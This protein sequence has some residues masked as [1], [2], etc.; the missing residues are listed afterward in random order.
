[1]DV[2]GAFVKIGGF[3]GSHA[4]IPREHMHLR[5]S[6][7]PENRQKSG[8][9]CA[10]PFY[11]APSLHIVEKK[12]SKESRT[13]SGTYPTKKGNPPSPGR[14]IPQHRERKINPTRK[15]SG[16]ISRENPPGYPRRQL[17]SGPLKLWKN[18]HFGPDIHDPKA[19]TSTTLR[20][21]KKF[22]KNPCAHKK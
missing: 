2:Q 10:L 22:Q 8:L 18:K 17:R 19:R 12:I 7:P 14:G 5:A 9:F 4:G 21:L 3:K 20:N 15:F 16:Q 11:N 6:N 1:M 13:Q